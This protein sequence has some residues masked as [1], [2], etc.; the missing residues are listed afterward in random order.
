MLYFWD[1]STD[2]SGP[3]S[4]PTEFRRRFLNYT[5]VAH[6][7]YYSSW[8]WNWNFLKFWCKLFLDI[9]SHFFEKNCKNYLYNVLDW[10]IKRLNY[11]K[12]METSSTQ[13]VCDTP[14]FFRT[15]NVLD[16][17][18]ITHQV[19]A[20]NNSRKLVFMVQEGIFSVKFRHLSVITSPFLWLLTSHLGE[21]YFNHIWWQSWKNF[22][23]RRK[24]GEAT[25]ILLA[26][27]DFC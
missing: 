6:D 8:N 20:K 14:N 7:L 23:K 15:I 1:V 19:R 4:R 9:N 11:K 24:N 26:W 16:Y 2:D 21:Y 3:L 5:Y 22:L 13:T 10:I 18:C 17:Y 12:I 25:V 27:V